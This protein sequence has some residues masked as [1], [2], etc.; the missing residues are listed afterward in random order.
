M[1]VVWKELILTGCFLAMAGVV[2]AGDRPGVRFGI[3]SFLG[4]INYS[5]IRGPEVVRTTPEDRTHY[6]D[7]VRELGVTTMRETFMNWAEIEPERGKAYQFEVFD[8][9][10]RKASDRGIE[11]VA[12]AYPFPSWAT[13]AK[14]TPANQRFTPMWQ[15]PQR[16]FE[17]DFRRFVHAMVARYCGQKAES[18]PLRLPIRH[19]IFSNELDQFK[20][21]PDEYALW[22]KVF[23]EEVKAVDPGATV[24]T[25]GF[26]WPATPV[27]ITFLQGM[28]AS[29]S[30]QGPAYP[31]FDVVAYHVYPFDCVPNI[32]VM[33]LAE[34]HTRWRLYD[35]KIN[36]ELW[37]TETGATRGGPDKQMDL[38]IKAV[39][40]AASTGVRRVYLQGLWDIPGWGGSVLKNTPSGQVPVRKPLFGAYQTLL[41]MIGENEGVQFLG[42]GR[43]RAWLS[44]G[45][46]IYIVWDEGTAK[47]RGGLPEGRIR[48][49][50]LERKQ[51]ETR[52]DQFT[53]NSHPALVEALE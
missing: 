12:L 23:Y 41:G 39:V 4:N 15:L 27:G 50:T 17:V 35:H 13:G 37:L 22:L 40:H 9:I 19:W 34:G 30:L 14:A 25:M 3:N 1:R 45:K 5:E 20:V 51:R 31:Y 26:T 7:A 38:A 10:A 16:Q 29:K 32:Y 53:P 11:I 42:P 18:L 8:D 44:G 48:I 46:S 49:T 43:Y 36:T 52:A 6:L 33:N 28:L 2:M 21:S 24:T 47:V